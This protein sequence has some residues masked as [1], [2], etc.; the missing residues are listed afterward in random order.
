MMKLKLSYPMTCWKKRHK[1]ENLLMR[2]AE[3]IQEGEEMKWL[4]R[5]I[6]RT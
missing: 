2:Y 5:K 6:E 1:F 4:R 3:E